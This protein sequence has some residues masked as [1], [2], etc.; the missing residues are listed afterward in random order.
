MLDSVEVPRRALRWFNAVAIAFVV[1]DVVAQTQ[2]PENVALINGQ[3]FT[4]TAF[5]PRTLYSVDGR[6][7]ATRPA[8]VDRTID[9]AGTWIVPP[10][11]EAHNHNIDG[12]VEER[13]RRAIARYLADGVFYVKIQ[14]NFP[15]SEALKRRLGVNSPTGPDVL[16][17]QAFLTSS[18]GHPIQLHE[19]ILLAQGYYPG[20]TRE[21][22]EDS[23]YITL[24]SEDDLETKWPRVRAL[25]PDF[26][27]ANL[28][29]SDEFEKRKSDP[30]YVGRRGLDPRL[31]QKLVVK[32]HRDSLR[33][34]VHITNAADFHHAVAAGADEIVHGGGPSPFNTIEDRMGDPRLVREPA[35]VGQLFGEALR[36]SNAYRPIAVDD[37]RLAAR[38]GIVVVTTVVSLT[39]APEAAR[40]GIRPAMAANL[41][42]LLDNGVTLAVGSDNVTDTSVLEVEQLATLGV[43]D[44]LAMLRMWA[45]TTPL[46]I[47][48]D[49]KIG[50][51]SE[52][53]EASFLALA[54][55][56]LEDLRHLREIKLRFK[57]GFPLEP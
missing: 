44:N 7:T 23:V 34:S 20:F 39:R 33:V 2:P 29:Y 53:Y 24:D 41:R 36:S 6:F 40:A 55:N 50:R 27:K 38:H 10:F 3:W 21:R 47:F 30:A 52:G 4:G 37:A 57:Q 8:R 45:E 25:R 48:P 32:A 56:P 42:L 22:L 1:S 43:L 13:S 14:G 5:E 49:R 12:V 15:V 26:I 46:A 28:W 17:A 18:G 31:L 35:R 51:L 19:Q 9:L 11:G 16:F 54:G